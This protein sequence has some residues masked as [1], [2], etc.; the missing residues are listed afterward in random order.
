MLTPCAARRRSDA[1]L[2]SLAS[3]PTPQ[4]QESA[5]IE[6]E[7]GD[8]DRAEGELVAIGAERSKALLRRQK[9]R[10]DE[11]PQKKAAPSNDDAG[12]HENQK[13]SLEQIRSDVRALEG[14][15]P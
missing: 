1:R 11:R 4:R 10:S 3:T 14:I 6:A 5:P 8:K 7:S 2:F 15:E 12:Q 13:I 9:S